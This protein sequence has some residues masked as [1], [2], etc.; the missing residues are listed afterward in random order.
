MLRFL[1]SRAFQGIFVIFCVLCITF[2]LTKA[3]PGGPQRNEFL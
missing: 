2:A 1:V 3:V